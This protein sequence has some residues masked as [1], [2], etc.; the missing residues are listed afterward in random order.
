VAEYYTAGPVAVD[1][2]GG[3]GGGA[4]GGCSPGRRAPGTSGLRLSWALVCL[5]AARVLSPLWRRGR[6]VRA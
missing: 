5:F 1:L 3:G 4:G 2:G 6:R